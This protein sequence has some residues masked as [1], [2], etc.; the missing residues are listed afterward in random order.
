[1]TYYPKKY[2]LNKKEPFIFQKN[3]PYFLDWLPT[4]PTRGVVGK[5]RSIPGRNL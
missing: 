2:K 4:L 3:Y 1:M 5:S